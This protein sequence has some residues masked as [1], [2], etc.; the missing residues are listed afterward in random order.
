MGGWLD[1]AKSSASFLVLIG[2]HYLFVPIL[3]VTAARAWVEQ[4]ADGFGTV[5]FYACYAGGHAALWI[6]FFESRPVFAGSL[7]ACFCC[8]RLRT[9]RSN[10][11]AT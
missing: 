9:P 3:V 6:A 7:W 11:R 2:L 4:G 1:D 10:C 8:C 5:A